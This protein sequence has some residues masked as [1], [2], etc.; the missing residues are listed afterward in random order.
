MFC[1]RCG[2]ELDGNRQSCPHC[3]AASSPQNTL[4]PATDSG[5]VWGILTTLFCCMPFG[6]VAIIYACQ[7]SSYAAA[8]NMA[9]AEQAIRSSKRYSLISAIVFSVLFTLFIL[10]QLLVPL[11][12]IL[13]A[14]TSHS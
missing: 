14:G 3:G 10:I 2:M 11:L 4:M 8:G 9:A 13:I 5:L 7:A 1:Q 12:I 6:I